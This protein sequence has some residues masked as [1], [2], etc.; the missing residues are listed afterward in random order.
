MIKYLSER[1]IEFVLMENGSFEA[2]QTASVS[3]N[4]KK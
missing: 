3:L 2:A 1:I 4:F